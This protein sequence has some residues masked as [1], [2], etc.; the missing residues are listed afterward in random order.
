MS[1][2]SGLAHIRGGTPMLHTLLSAL[3]ANTSNDGTSG[4]AQRRY[5]RRQVDRCVAVLHG[6][7]FPIENWSQGGVLIGADERLFSLGSELDLTL[8][9]KLRNTIVD[10]PVKSQVVRKTN[11]HVAMKFEPVGATIKRAFQQVID[12]HVARQFANSQV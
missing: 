7:T 10:V 2:K 9:F 11:G 1:Q 6:R 4:E 5:P 8:K 3:K 12:D